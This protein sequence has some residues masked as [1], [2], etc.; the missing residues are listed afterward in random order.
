M[1]PCVN[2]PVMHHVRIVTFAVRDLLA[3][4]CP[5]SG[6]SP[7]GRDG[8]PRCRASRIPHGNQLWASPSKKISARNFSTHEYLQPRWMESGR[9]ELQ[10]R[11]GLAEIL[12]L[13]SE[14][15]NS[16]RFIG[17]VTDETQGRGMR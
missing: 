17:R 4:S 2:G 3:H 8:F 10:K 1:Q 11:E 14:A 15:E 12:P 16:R 7:L 13:G 5:G 9:V 6:L